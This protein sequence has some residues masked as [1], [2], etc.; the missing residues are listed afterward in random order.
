MIYES[1][2]ILNL[3]AGYERSWNRLAESIY[4][5]QMLKIKHKRNRYFG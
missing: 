1:I 4:Y 5:L 2:S 3:E